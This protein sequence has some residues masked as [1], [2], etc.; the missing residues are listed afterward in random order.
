MLELE[1]K[2]KEYSDE[3]NKK[4]ESQRKFLI[5]LTVLSIINI[6]LKFI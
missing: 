4:A 6:I 3:L 2:I 1:N 5:I